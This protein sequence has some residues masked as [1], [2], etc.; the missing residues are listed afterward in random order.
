MDMSLS[1]LWESVMDREALCASVHR[2]VLWEN[3][4][5]IIPSYFPWPTPRYSA[6]PLH[7]QAPAL[8]GGV[9]VRRG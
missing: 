8:W 1:K 5:A 7:S 2:N 6:G 9:A 4:E 3:A